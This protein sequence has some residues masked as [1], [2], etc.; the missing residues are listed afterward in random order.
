MSGVTLEC[1]ECGRLSGYLHDVDQARREGW[2]LLQYVDL[3]C[4]VLCPSCSPCARP[5]LSPSDEAH[6][7]AVRQ[8]LKERAARQQASYERV[9]R[10]T[11]ASPPSC[12]RCASPRLLCYDC[13]AEAP[14]PPPRT[15][16]DG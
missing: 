15:G 6:I 3:S 14:G 1:G 8:R 16:R 9:I 11:E 13:G 10:D 2:F 7:E 4:T 5:D 12:P